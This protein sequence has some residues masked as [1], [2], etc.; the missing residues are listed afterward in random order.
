MQNCAIKFLCCQHCQYCTFYYKILHIFLQKNR[1]N[2]NCTK[3]LF[4][5]CTTF[6]KVL[7]SI[8]DVFIAQSIV[9]YC[10][11]YW[12]VLHK[13]LFIILHNCIVCKCVLVAH[14]GFCFA[15]IC[16]DLLHIG[17]N[18]AIGCEFFSNFGATCCL[19]QKSYPKS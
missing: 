12:S 6:H 13:V 18:T 16:S 10:T 1:I 8:I 11:K 5:Y 3:V 17:Y 14:F 2:K 19:L 9:L 7:N 4:I 15:H